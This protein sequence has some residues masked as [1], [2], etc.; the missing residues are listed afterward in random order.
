MSNSS[1]PATY[2]T[3][4]YAFTHI[5]IS[6]AIEFLWTKLEQVDIND[7]DP[8]DRICAICQ[9][10]FHVSDDAERSHPPVKTICDHIFG[11]RCITRWLNPMCSYRE[12]FHRGREPAKTSCPCCRHVFFPV[13]NKEPMEELAQRLH[14]W[15]LAFASAGVIRSEKEER[16]R[17]YLWE[18]IQYFCSVNEDH[19]VGARLRIVFHRVAQR[20]LQQFVVFYKAQQLDSAEQKNQ[21]IRLERIARKDLS[22]CARLS[23]GSYCFDINCDDDERSEFE[24]QPMEKAVLET[25]MGQGMLTD[26]MAGPMS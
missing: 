20:L 14:F 1:T 26:N 12:F 24:G 23:D 5:G 18:Y 7:L 21:G 3:A 17:K 10:E 6:D 11:K 25:D 2:E 19:G 13:R 4:G 16:T 9:E 8:N 15:D 22:K